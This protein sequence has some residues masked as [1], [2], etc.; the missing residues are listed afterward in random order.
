M[1]IKI[2][3]ITTV[4]ILGA[5]IFAA[6]SATIGITNLISILS[7]AN[8]LYITLAIALFFMSY[9]FASLGTWHILDK[10]AKKWF[11]FKLY[12]AGYF[13]NNIT[14][15]VGCGGE[16]VKAEIIS[17]HAGLRKTTVFAAILVQKI[18]HYIP[19]IYTMFLSAA[20]LIHTN[21]DGSIP[22]VIGG[23]LVLSAIAGAFISL[24]ISKNQT[25]IHIVCR[26]LEAI[27]NSFEKIELHIRHKKIAK[28]TSETIQ[29]FHKQAHA[30]FWKR[31]V[32]VPQMYVLL[33]IASEIAT[34]YLVILA[35]GQTI[36]LPALILA[37]TVAVTIGSVPITP[38]GLGTYDASLAGM[39]LMFSIPLEH[40]ITA[41]LLFRL[42][43]Y[44]LTNVLGLI[45]LAMVEK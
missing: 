26:T 33:S 43:Q 35:I 30:I 25:H 38:G 36:T 39:L 10:K 13:L 29:K 32:L 4:M 3:F 42:I 18:L 1:Q 9:A 17:K 11:L 21:P 19:F 5:I 23:A 31:S 6:F 7:H 44:W 40:A 28:N 2:K 27:L 24:F 16:I 45:A 22:Y 15:I 12:I 41:A 14:P 37:Y 20:I 34:L 8:P